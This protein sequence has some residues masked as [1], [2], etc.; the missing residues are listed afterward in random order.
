MLS[1]V[2]ISPAFTLRPAVL[3]CSLLYLCPPNFTSI[4]TR[5]SATTA[6]NTPKPQTMTQ[7]RQTNTRGQL[8]STA[9][10]KLSHRKSWCVQTDHGAIFCKAHLTLAHD[11]CIAHPAT[12]GSANVPS[13]K[14]DVLSSYSCRPNRL[15]VPSSTRVY[16]PILAAASRCPVQSCPF[17]DCYWALDTSTASF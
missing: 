2:P 17:A 5:T 4:H 1:G 14:N 3:N 10:R 15:G 6:K 7:L 9:V 12:C 8:A 16:S 13:S 11:L